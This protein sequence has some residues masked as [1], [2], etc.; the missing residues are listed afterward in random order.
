MIICPAYDGSE[1]ISWYPVIEVLKHIS[2]TTFFLA[3]MANPEKTDLSCRTIFALES[4]D[5]V[6]LLS[7]LDRLLVFIKTDSRFIGT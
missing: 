2:P 3:P 5:R 7:F 1:I 6:T 4:K